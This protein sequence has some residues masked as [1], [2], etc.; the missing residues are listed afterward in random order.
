MSSMAVGTH[1]F[2]TAIVRDASEQQ[3]QLARLRQ[4]SIVVD[5]SDNAIFISSAD[6]EVV[7]VNSGFTRM[8]GY[9]LEEQE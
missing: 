2:H 5:S 3:R 4:L 9:R 7:Y 8:L 1:A 6:R